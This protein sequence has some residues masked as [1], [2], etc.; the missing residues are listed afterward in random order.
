MVVDSDGRWSRVGP[1]RP[2][3]S[4]W[5]TTAPSVVYT[6]DLTFRLNTLDRN[7]SVGSRGRALPPRRPADLYLNNTTQETQRMEL[8]VNVAVIWKHI[9]WDGIVAGAMN[10]Y[11]VLSRGY[12]ASVWPV[13]MCFLPEAPLENHSSCSL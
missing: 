2:S 7:H 8:F 5:K 9:I 6:H 11:L 10:A 13:V 1:K 12:F 3:S 4:L